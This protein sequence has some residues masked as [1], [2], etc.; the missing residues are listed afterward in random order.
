MAATSV[1]V[2]TLEVVVAKEGS[3]VRNRSGYVRFGV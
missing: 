3:Q 1:C 2:A